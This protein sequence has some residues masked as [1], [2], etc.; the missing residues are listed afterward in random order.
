MATWTCRKKQCSITWTGLGPFE[1]PN[2]WREIFVLTTSGWHWWRKVREDGYSWS[3][4]MILEVW[5]FE[6]YFL[7]VSM[8]IVKRERGVEF[9]CLEAH[10]SAKLLLMM[11]IL[12]VLFWMCRNY[13]LLAWKKPIWSMDMSCQVAC[14]LFCMLWISAQIKKP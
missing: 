12:M 3:R 13:G 7:C 11:L 6:D 14:F 1:L 8:C 5:I 4:V 10:R 9:W 2:P